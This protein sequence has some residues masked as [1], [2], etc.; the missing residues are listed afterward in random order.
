MNPYKIIQE[1][2][3]T[4]G[5]SIMVTS[6]PHKTEGAVEEMKREVIS[7][8]EL[9]SSQDLLAKELRNG[10]PKLKKSEEGQVVFE[11]FFKKERLIVFGGGHIA[12]PL[13]QMAA[14]TG[15]SVTVVDDRP[16]FANVGRFPD[17]E[18][19]I[20]ND[21]SKAFEAL[22]IS[23]SDFLVVIT[24]GHRY[25]EVCLREILSREETLYTGMIGSKKR[26][27]KVFSDLIDEGYDQE[28]IQRICSPIGLAIGAITP[29]EITISI[30]A[31]LIK[32]RRLDDVNAIRVNRSDMETDLIHDLAEVAE[33]CAL[34]TVVETLGSAPRSAGAKM[35]VGK[36]GI[37]AGSIGG[38]CSESEVM[39]TARNIIGTR[40]WLIQDINLNSED[41][42]KEGMVCGGSMKVLIE[43]LN[44][45]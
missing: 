17:A 27:A 30:L 28:R 8:S 21:F 41:A 18:T 43:D 42:E 23:P 13:C 15:F 19:V 35:L 10:K 2:L 12:L 26:V 29:E 5:A 11:P 24:R 6:L 33:A 44:L 4:E 20:C 7:E 14:M 9:R 31:E 16:S 34:V 32:R 1:H 37:L 22:A 39:H 36:L 25:D 38:G 40:R 45:D 3:L